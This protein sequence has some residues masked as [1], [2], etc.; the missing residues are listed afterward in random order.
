[1]RLLYVPLLAAPARNF[2]WMRSRRCFWFT[3]ATP[4]VT[5]D[6]STAH[7]SATHAS[8]RHR[9]ARWRRA[10]GASDVIYLWRADT[11]LLSVNTSISSRN[12]PRARAACPDRARTRDVPRTHASTLA[13][14]RCDRA[15]TARRARYSDVMGA[16]TLQTVHR[17][18]CARLHAWD[19]CVVI[20]HTFSQN[21]P[22][23]II[24]RS[25]L[26]EN[27]YLT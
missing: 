22:Y 5:V 3:S 4:T 7:A 12:T 13:S 26:G 8:T 20:T 15:R 27:Q 11:V 10:R 6:A 1:M 24:P 14:V 21:C 17:W 25:P 23:R 9:D 19:A 16:R 18:T 2:C